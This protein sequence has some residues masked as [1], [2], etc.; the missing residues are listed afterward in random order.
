MLIG[1][2]VIAAVR[3][4]DFDDL[5][6]EIG[7]GLRAGRPCH[8]TCEIYDQQTVKDGRRLFRSRHMVGQRQFR[9]GPAFPS[10]VNARR[11]FK[12]YFP[13]ATRAAAP[14]S[15][16]ACGYSPSAIAKLGRYPLAYVK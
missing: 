5:R 8:H 10:A 2:R 4:F 3:V 12:I 14:T 16:A 15:S 7:Q 9:H 13:L 1:P 11:D 6:A